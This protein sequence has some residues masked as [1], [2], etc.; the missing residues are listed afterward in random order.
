MH[1]KKVGRRSHTIIE[2]NNS[3]ELFFRTTSFCIL[4][5]GDDIRQSN[6]LNAIQC[7]EVDIA[8]R[9][10]VCIFQ[11]PGDVGDGCPDSDSSG[12]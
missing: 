2:C 10:P 8:L 11:A 6:T 7:F 1:R 9:V 5:I 3:L 12:D 4:G